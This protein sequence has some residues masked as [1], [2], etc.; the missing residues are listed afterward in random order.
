MTSA[1]SAPPIRSFRIE[2][3]LL[4]GRLAP[5]LPAARDDLHRPAFTIRG[6]AVRQPLPPCCLDGVLARRQSRLRAVAAHLVRKP[7]DVDRLLDVAGEA[8]RRAASRSSP[9]SVQ[10][11][12]CDDRDPRRPRFVPR[13]RAASAPSRSGSREVHQD[14]VRQALGR[15]RDPLGAGL[16]LQR[17]EPG[18]AQHVAGELQV[19]ARCRR[20]SGRA[21][22][23][24]SSAHADP[25]RA[26]RGSLPRPRGAPAPARDAARPRGRCRLRRPRFAARGGRRGKAGRRRHRHPDAAGQRRRGD[27][28]RRAP[29][30]HE[31]G[32]RRRG[33]Q[34]VREFRAMSSRSSS[35]A[36]RGA[37]TC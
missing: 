5:A 17:P 6:A 19:L 30:R 36:A 3:R 26:R 15:E 7:A 4:S 14:D 25:A 33:A 12:Q 13:A 9:P 28:G 27:S 10:R 8:R 11:A 35:A 37:R 16:C 20:R 1:P 32:A 21:G 23:G 18:G 2:V 22:T 31:S 24:V 29:A 34:P